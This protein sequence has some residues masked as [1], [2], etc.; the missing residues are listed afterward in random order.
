MRTRNNRVL[1]VGLALIVLAAAF[2]L[3]FMVVMAAKSNDPATMMTTVG[4]AAG[5]VGGIGFVMVIFGMIG[6]KA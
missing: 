5:A 4:Q 6:R 3:Y 2:F 1:V